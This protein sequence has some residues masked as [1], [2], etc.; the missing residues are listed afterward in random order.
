MPRRSAGPSAFPAEILRSPSY[1]SEDF[2]PNTASDPKIDEPLS[3]LK[4]KEKK[5]FGKTTFPATNV[6]TSYAM[7]PLN[8]K[9]KQMAMNTP[10]IK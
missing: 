10:V 8:A 6:A 3:I 7:S 2:S 1:N 5:C 9:L 4:R